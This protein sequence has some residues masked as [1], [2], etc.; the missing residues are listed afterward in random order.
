MTEFCFDGDQVSV[1]AS[2]NPPSHIDR[3]VSTL[4]STLVRAKELQ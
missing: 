4:E 3:I 1:E 2:S